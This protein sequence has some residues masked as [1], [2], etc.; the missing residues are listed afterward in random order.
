MLINDSKLTIEVFDGRGFYTKTGQP[1]EPL[2]YI[3]CEKQKFQLNH[4]TI[5]DKGYDWGERVAM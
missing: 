1:F 2:V 5:K 4:P 3:F